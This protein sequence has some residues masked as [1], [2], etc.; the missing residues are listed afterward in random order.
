MKKP[1]LNNPDEPLRMFHDGACPLC[2]LE[3][4]HYRKLDREG[5]ISFIDATCADKDVSAQLVSA[6]LTQA[7][8]LRRLH[9]V[10]PDGRIVSGARAFVAL[11]RVLPRWRRI[12]P[13]A[14]APP[15]IWILEG[16]Y[17]L[18]LPIRPLLARSLGRRSQHKDVAA[19]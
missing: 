13:I 7:V 14:G 18:F 9:V 6:G 8:A 16:L 4:A 5:K 3:V 19:P 11:W 12:A 10:L 17:R 2:T 1:T 15:I